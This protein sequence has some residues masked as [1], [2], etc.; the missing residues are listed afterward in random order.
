MKIVTPT[1]T[2]CVSS[3]GVPPAAGVTFR[4]TEKSPVGLLTGKK[5]YVFAAR[6]GRYAGTPL[7]TQTPYLRN[8]LT[9]LGMSDVEFVYAE[10]LAMG[11]G[12]N[13][14]NGHLS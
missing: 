6:G 11:H 4:Y 2:L 5:A 7:D 1:L 13:N 3:G 8:V 14:R 10:G 9:F 12:Y